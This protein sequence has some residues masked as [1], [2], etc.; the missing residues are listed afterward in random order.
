[1]KRLFGLIPLIILS[2]LLIGGWNNP[3]A[4]GD[5][6]GSPSSA[7]H[8]QPS[9]RLERVAIIYDDDGSPDGT[10]ANLYLLANPEADLKVISISYGEA[11]PSTYIQHIGNMLEVF[12]IKGIDLG[13]GDNAPLAGNNSFPVWITEMADN[14]WNMYDLNFIPDLGHSYTS[15]PAAD[16]IISTVH[17]SPEPITLFFAGAYTSLAQALRDDPSIRENIEAVYLMGGAVYVP[18]NIRELIPNSHNVWAEWNIYADPVAA[19]EVFNSG[20][21]LYLVPLDATNL[22]RVDGWDTHHWRQG[23][24]IGDLAAD[25]WDSMLAAWGGE[26]VMW[27]ATAAILMMEPELCDFVP[28]RLGVVTEDGTISAHS[29]QTYVIPNARPNISVCLEP[30]ADEVR[31]HLIDIFT[32]SN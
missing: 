4:Q 20:M 18:G 8:P 30:D 24:Q 22:V 10:L 17:S 32:H 1:M 2:S 16:L 19:E 27:D 12:G 25:L 3:E 23:G 14:F 13:N 7:Y 26:G 31:R 21:E 9:K 15:T 6:R 28:L 5:T 29:G 11:T